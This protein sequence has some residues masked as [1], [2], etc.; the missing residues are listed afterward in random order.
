MLSKAKIKFIA[1]LKIKKNRIEQELFTAEGAK[2]LDELLS[3]SVLVR[4]IYCLDSWF[5]THQQLLSK[6][7]INCE[8]IAENELNKISSLS[9]PNEVLAVCSIPQNSYSEATIRQ[10]L[11]LALDGIH[12][13]VIWALYYV[14]QTG[15]IYLIYFV[16]KT[17]WMSIMP[18]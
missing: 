2:T 1:S 9:T 3:S 18:K 16:L 4:E 6:T 11:C 12:D 8:V 13:P 17:V 7:S 10:E 5:Y 14:L 15:L